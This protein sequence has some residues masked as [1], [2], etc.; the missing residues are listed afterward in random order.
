MSGDGDSSLNSGK[1]KQ[2]SATY[3]FSPLEIQVIE[4]TENE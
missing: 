4:R 1:L 3:N 2:L